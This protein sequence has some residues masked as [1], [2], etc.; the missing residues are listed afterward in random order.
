[1]RDGVRSPGKNTK[2]FANADTWLMNGVTSLRF[3]HNAVMEFESS[4]QNHENCR[5]GRRPP[6]TLATFFCVFL[7]LDDDS[8]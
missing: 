1:M 3:I 2:Y 8:C 4:C 7:I 6:N 5:M